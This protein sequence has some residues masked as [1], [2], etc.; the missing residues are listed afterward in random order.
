MHS[1]FPLGRFCKGELKMVIVGKM[2]LDKLLYQLYDFLESRNLPEAWKEVELLKRCGNNGI[3]D[4]LAK[5]FI[6]FVKKNTLNSMNTYETISDYIDEIFDVS[7]VISLFALRNLKLSE[8]KKWNV[9]WIIC[10]A[11]ETVK[12]GIWVSR[13]CLIA[14]MIE[15]GKNAK[16]TVGRLDYENLEKT[17]VEDVGEKWVNKFVNNPKSDSVITGLL[18]FFPSYKKNKYPT[19]IPKNYTYDLSYVLSDT[20]KEYVYNIDCSVCKKKHTIIFKEYVKK[21]EKYESEKYIDVKDIIQFKTKAKKSYVVMWCPI[22][23]KA[24]LVIDID[25]KGKSYDDKCNG[26]LKIFYNLL[27]DP[28]VTFSRSLAFKDELELDNGS[29]E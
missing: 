11:K 15:K 10:E 18:K 28:E 17:L 2:A 7:D 8:Q 13:L 9:D 3:E 25:R 20:D 12:K 1:N 14:A 29:F 23:N 27:N 21:N 24:A 4:L 6:F 19:K 5:P 16:N 26:L 22:N